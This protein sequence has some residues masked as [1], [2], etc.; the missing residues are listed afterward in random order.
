M[1]VLHVL[2]TSL[3]DHSGS[4]IR[5][6]G[7]VSS[8]LK[9]GLE[10]T[11]ITSPF[12]KPM[13][14]GCQE[15]VFE[16][17]THIRTYNGKASQQVDE[18][19]SGIVKQL[20]KLFQVFTF[21]NKVYSQAKKQNVEVI[22]AHSTFFCGL[23]AIYA[24]RKLAIPSVYEVRS[25]WEERAADRNGSRFS[26]VLA[27]V[28]RRV[29]TYVM[30]RADHVV[31]INNALKDDILK[32]G[33]DS[34]KVTVVVN[35]VEDMT[36]EN[37][38]DSSWPVNSRDGFVFSYI[39][40]VSPIEGLDL[41]L[42]AWGKFFK[43][44][45]NCQLKVFGGGI[46]SSRLSEIICTEKLQNVELCG[47]FV[48]ADVKDIYASVDVV[49]NPR[50]KS[51]LTDTVTPLKPL[52]A[53]AYKKL[54]LTSDVG[55]MNALVENAVTGL[56]FKSGDVDDLVSFLNYVTNEREEVLSNIVEAGRDYVVSERSWTK[57]SN[58]YKELYLN[59]VHRRSS[60]TVELAEK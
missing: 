19:G 59:L 36:L 14:P 23:A 57:N 2:Y 16:G 51:R 55:G 26:K 37:G 20:N 38:R 33:V 42:E 53:M 7:V 30:N 60:L 32:R 8:Q 22:H 18:N 6:R 11:V 5:S 3:P 34:E 12:Q 1:K 47:P 45:M 9:L 50:N 13:E 58:I 31:V 35:A 17:V 44:G 29:E 46:F 43:K 4:S 49:V 41:L 10:P 39:G 40:S 56:Q 28:I 15:E 25:L 48:P 24:A 21:R 27:G 54:V 52:E